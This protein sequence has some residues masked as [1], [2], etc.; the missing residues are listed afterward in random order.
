MVMAMSAQDI[1]KEL[2][3]GGE[4]V[5][6]TLS[7]VW[8]LLC[9]LSPLDILGRHIRDTG[10]VLGGDFPRENNKIIPYS[11]SRSCTPYLL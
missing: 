10:P 2:R 8:C 6:V 7:K 3:A 11:T 1:I 4:R 9:A 5:D